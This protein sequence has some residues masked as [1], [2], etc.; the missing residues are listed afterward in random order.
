MCGQR[1]PTS[2]ISVEMFVYIAKFKGEGAGQFMGRLLVSETIFGRTH[3][4]LTYGNNGH[5][6]FVSVTRLLKR[7]RNHYLP[8]A[9]KHSK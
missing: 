3:Y 9:S 8:S 5:S 7:H 6:I 4:D 2:S 1:L